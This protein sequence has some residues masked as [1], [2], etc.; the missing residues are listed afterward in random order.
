MRTKSKKKFI[1]FDTI[2]K[3]SKNEKLSVWTG[4][5]GTY[6]FVKPV[7]LKMASQVFLNRKYLTG[8]F[9][10][11]KKNV[12]S[13]DIREVAGKCYLKFEVVSDNEIRIEKEIKRIKY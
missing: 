3:K 6:L 9:R 4:S 5:R 1:I 7:N 10:T 11:D 8:L 12:Y 2:V 13:G